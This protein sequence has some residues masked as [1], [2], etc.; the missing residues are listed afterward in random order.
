MPGPRLFRPRSQRKPIPALR[1]CIFFHPLRSAVPVSRAGEWLAL[2]VF[3]RPVVCRGGDIRAPTRENGVLVRWVQR[4]FT[5]DANSGRN[6]S[7]EQKKSPFL[8]ETAILFGTT[9]PF[10]SSLPLLVLLSQ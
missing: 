7:L 1:C 10:P 5:Q 4:L 2:R 8:Y 3:F 6:S 9:Y